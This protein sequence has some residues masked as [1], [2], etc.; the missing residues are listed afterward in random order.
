MTFL[1]LSRLVFVLPSPGIVRIP[2]RG[3]KI[4]SPFRI[5]F[6]RAVHDA[7]WDADDVG[8]DVFLL[9]RWVLF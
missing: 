1:S 4:F 9:R 6:P 8:S 7:R 5:P 3:I 2:F